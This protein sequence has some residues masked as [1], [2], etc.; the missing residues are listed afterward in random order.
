[1]ETVTRDQLPISSLTWTA[2]ALRRH[3]TRLLIV[4]G[5]LA[6]ACQNG[7]EALLDNLAISTRVDAALAADPATAH[8]ELAVEGNRGQI[9]LQGRIRNPQDPVEVRRVVQSITGGI[10][11]HFERRGTWRTGGG[12]ARRPTIAGSPCSERGR[13]TWPWA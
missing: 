7:K 2:R 12:L 11:D 13:R 5:E 9:Q 8:L 6:E 3:G 1:M 4:F 10:P